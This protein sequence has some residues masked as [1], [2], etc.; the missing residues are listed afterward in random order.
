MF[1]ASLSVLNY[2]NIV[3]AD[4]AFSPK[5]NCFIGPN[6]EGKTNLLDAI[7]YLSF[8]HSAT[9]PT[10]A[11]VVRHGEESMAIHGVY[12]SDGG[13]DEVISAGIAPGRRKRFS[14]NRK[15]YRR[16]AEHIGL[17]PL[18]MISP[19]DNVLVTG[20]GEERRKF[21]DTVISQY[22]NIYLDSLIKY[23]RALQQRNALLRGE[24]EPD[25]SILGV[26]EE[27]MAFEGERIFAKRS[28]FI[29]RLTP[30]FRNY[31]SLIS[32]DKEEVELAY[33]SHCMRG[34]LLEV[35]QRDRAK[36]RIMGYSLHGI[37]RDELEMRLGGY[38]IR[39]EGSQGQAKSFLVALKF[40]QFEL[41]KHVGKRTVSLL[42]LD[43]LFDKLDAG[44][45]AQIVELVA[46]DDFGQ[47]FITDTNRDHLDSILAATQGDYRLF[48]VKNGE[49]SE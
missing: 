29:E 31:Y 7:Y 21:M 2:K 4:L 10:D 34:P 15:P 44:R 25:A 33:T 12:K 36:D 14:R 45:V 9:T 13:E 42:L 27:I 37:H 30:I 22:D 41:L 16:L 49:V 43:D 23:N 32:N 11:Q 28:D 17:V 6:G 5:I 38:P 35:I 26:F 48:K 24:E 3:Q 40:A 20:G 39:R 46:G 47:I 18:V 8:C 1:L 19:Q